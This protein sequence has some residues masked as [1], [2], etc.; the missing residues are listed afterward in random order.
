[1]KI[2]YCI[3]CTSHSGGM[4]RVLANKANYLARHGYEIVVVTTDQRGAQPFFLLE[5]GIRCIDLGSIRFDRV[6]YRALPLDDVK[7]QPVTVVDVR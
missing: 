6:A 5:P 7:R 1:M 4:E 2:I 3:A